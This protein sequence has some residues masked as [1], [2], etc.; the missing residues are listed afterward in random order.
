MTTRHPT[1]LVLFYQLDS[2]PASL[3]L[4]GV[5]FDH[6]GCAALRSLHL[7]S[8]RHLRMRPSPISCNWGRGSAGRSI[9]VLGTSLPSIVIFSALPS[10]SCGRQG[11]ELPCQTHT[12]RQVETPP[13]FLPS[14]RAHTL[15]FILPVVR[16]LCIRPDTICI[17]GF[18]CSV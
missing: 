5:E 10:E 6:Q 15:A 3:E 9:L 2:R 1:G 13:G 7:P 8:S 17:L 4:C 12:A 16:V 11:C 18:S 14:P